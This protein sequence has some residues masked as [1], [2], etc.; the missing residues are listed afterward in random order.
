[1][2]AKQNTLL[3]I[4]RWSVKFCGRYMQPYSHRKS[5][6]KFTDAQLMSCLIVR[7]LPSIAWPPGFDDA[8]ITLTNLLRRSLLFHQHQFN[9]QADPRVD[10]FRGRR[11]L[12]IQ[13]AVDLGYVQLRYQENPYKELRDSGMQMDSNRRCSSVAWCFSF[14][15]VNLLGQLLYKRLERSTID[16]NDHHGDFSRLSEVVEVTEICIGDERINEARPNDQAADDR[17]PGCS[18]RDYKNHHRFDFA[19]WCLSLENRLRRLLYC[20]EVAVRSRP[21]CDQG[22]SPCARIRQSIRLL[23]M[24]TV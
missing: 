16:D 2:S 14:P 3:K 15:W 7:I 19:G 23:L 17:H 20:V 10:L 8:S 18:K 4:A 6:H 11:S 22:L 12:I 13:V 5:P 1:M 9:Q 24:P 21:F